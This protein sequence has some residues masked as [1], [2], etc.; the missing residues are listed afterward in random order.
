MQ[1]WEDPKVIELYRSSASK[2]HSKYP[3]Y[4]NDDKLYPMLMDILHE[5]CVAMRK[6]GASDTEISIFRIDF[7]IALQTVEDYIV[8]PHWDNMNTCPGQKSA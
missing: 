7:N 6:N 4:E 3:Q 5:R 8:H 2:L 1:S